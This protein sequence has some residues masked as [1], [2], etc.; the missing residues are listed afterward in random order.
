V[1]KYFFYRLS[2]PVLYLEVLPQ[3]ELHN[4]DN[5]SIKREPHIVDATPLR[6][7]VEVTMP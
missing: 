2:L 5:N 4:T 1:K 7:N 3:A 6:G